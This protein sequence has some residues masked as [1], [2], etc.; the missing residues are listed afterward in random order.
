MP[1]TPRHLREMAQM[2]LSNKRM[3]DKTS[4]NNQAQFSLHYEQTDSWLCLEEIYTVKLGPVK[5]GAQL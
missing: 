3:D 4:N 2:M 1:H 5:P